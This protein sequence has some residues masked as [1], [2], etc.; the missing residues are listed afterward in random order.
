MKKVF[1]S[2][3]LMFSPAIGFKGSHR[4]LG[5]HGTGVVT[6]IEAMQGTTGGLVKQTTQDVWIWDNSPEDLPAAS[7]ATCN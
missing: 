1:A 4:E 7:N 5:G 2:M 3:M 6:H